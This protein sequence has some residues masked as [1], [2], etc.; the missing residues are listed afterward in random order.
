MLLLHGTSSALLGS[1]LAEGMR[2]PA[3]LASR[4]D[5]AQFW[6]DEAVARYGGK[7]AF[8]IVDIS[9]AQI[10]PDML[11]WIDAPAGVPEDLVDEWRDS[12]EPT[13]D[14]AL[15]ITASVVVAHMITT[16]QILRSS[17]SPDLP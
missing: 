2:A 9:M 1:I 16:K 11:S 4:A 10:E 14:Q 12:D 7:A 13:L 3:Y 8:V 17:S 15:R 6:A 5:V